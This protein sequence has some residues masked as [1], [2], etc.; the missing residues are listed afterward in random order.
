MEASMSDSLLSLLTKAR[1]D[2][3]STYRIWFCGGARVRAFREVRRILKKA[4]ARIEE[5]TFGNAYRGSLLEEVLRIICTQGPFFRAAECAFL[6]K[7]KLRSPGFYEDADHQ[8]ALG[9]LI[10]VCL[11]DSSEAKII[12]AV[13]QF[14]ALRIRGA[15]PAIANLLYFLRPT[16]LPP[17]NTAIVQGYN[18]ITDANIRSGNWDDYLALRQGILNLNA[19]YQALLSTD[20]GAIAGVLFDVGSR[21]YPVPQSGNDAQARDTNVID[22]V[23]MPVERPS[24][25]ID[26][27]QD[28]RTHTGVQRLL[29]GL[30]RL[31]GFKIW[32]AQ[33]DRNRMVDGGKLADG[34]LDELSGIVHSPV[35]D[36]VRLIDVLW[37]DPSSGR[38]VAAFEVEHTTDAARGM[39][40]MLCLACGPTPHA[41]KAMFIV[42]PDN[43]ERQIRAQLS[44]PV[45]KRPDSP[46][47]LFIPYSELEANQSSIA[48]SGGGVTS[49]EA[50]ARQLP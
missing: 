31:L 12:S 22:L 4:V 41:L 32:V 7:P 38:V 15:G 50:I 16:L 25:I 19:R 42:A 20:L 48:R 3:S 28:G 26:N 35:G 34:C 47:L 46:K 37:V 17:Y 5:G 44:F 8:R 2:P 1:S 29:L 49:L 27:S 30:G 18:A 40:R 24:V 14:A 45:F 21:R 39:I 6:W 9:L 36:A 43:R 11:G 13:R 33:N 10:E 23:R